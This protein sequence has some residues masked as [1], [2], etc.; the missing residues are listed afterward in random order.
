MEDSRARAIPGE[1]VVVG[2]V[3]SRRLSAALLAA[4]PVV[5]RIGL[6]WWGRG[7][8]PRL[9]P[10]PRTGVL[11]HTD[12]RLTKRPFGRWKVRV[13]TTRWTADHL[14]E[15]ATTT[16]VAPAPAALRLLAVGLARASRVRAGSSAPS[17]RRLPAGDHRET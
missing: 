5:I 13:T 2:S 7:Q 17:F 8:R 10:P 11:E 1:I 16:T 3:S 6:W 12:M 9:S 15:L 4:A 14:P